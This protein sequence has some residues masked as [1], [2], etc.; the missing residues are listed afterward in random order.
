[1]I[2]NAIPVLAYHKVGAPV[3]SST[4]RFLNISPANFRRQMSAFYRLGFS[5]LTLANVVEYIRAG[6]TLPPRSFVITFDD[7]Y[8]CVGKVA[9]PILQEFGFQATVFVVSGEVGGVNIWDRAANKPQVPLMNWSDLKNLECMGWEIGGH[10]VSH[11]HLDKLDDASARAEILLGKL[12]IEEQ[13]NRKIRSFCYPAGL[14]NAST[15]EFVRD[16][17]FSG[18]CT[19]RTGMVTSHQDPFL[20]P[21]IKVAYKDG[22]IGLLYRMLLRPSLPNMRPNRRSHR[23]PLPVYNSNITK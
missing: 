12:E 20:L 14:F 8:D 13:L 3:T 5:S 9:S 16:A 21:R 22:L 7:G 11:P 10:T 4:D 15:P 19:V 6:K 2:N 18:A 17:G 1:M 23:I